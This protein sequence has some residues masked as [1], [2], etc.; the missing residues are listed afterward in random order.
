MTVLNTPPSDMLLRLAGFESESIVDGPGLRMVLFTQGCPH[1]CPGCHNPNTHLLVGGK[2]C[3]V[4]D[5]LRIYQENET[6]QGITFSGGEPF[7]HAKQLHYIAKEVH[8]LGGNVISYT[9]FTHQQLRNRESEDIDTLLGEIDLL[10]DG[11]YIEKL[12]R[13][14]LLY[15]GSL[16]QKYIALTPIGEQLKN[17][18]D[19]LENT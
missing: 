4:G 10:I 16:N 18:I 9:G 3:K 17:K 6:L 12:R 15:K 1:R 7:L 13:P 19:K 14:N 11:P 5:L 8:A 2:L